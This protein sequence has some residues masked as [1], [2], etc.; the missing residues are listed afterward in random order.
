MKKLFK[1]FKRFGYEEIE[2]DYRISGTTAHVFVK[3][4]RGEGEDITAVPPGPF[5]LRLEQQ[6]ATLPMCAAGSWC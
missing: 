5:V 1:F 4:I 6:K 3:P 2:S